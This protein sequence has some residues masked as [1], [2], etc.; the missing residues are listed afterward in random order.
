MIT[1]LIADDEPLTCNYLAS[2]FQSQNW[3][4][5][6]HTAYSGTE[7]LDAMAKTAFHLMLLDI[8]MPGA[9][10]LEIA[11]EASRLYP[12]TRILFL[13]AYDN[14][15]Y[16]YSAVSMN[17]R[18]YLLKI[19]P[20][21]VILEQVRKVIDEILE[22]QE[23]IIQIDEIRRKDLML[24]FLKQ[25]PIL[26][27]IC[28]SHDPEQIR[29]KLQSFPRDHVPQLS[30]PFYMMY[31]SHT[32]PADFLNGQPGMEEF[33]LENIQLM[34]SL[35]CGKLNCYILR[36][37]DSSFLYLFQ[38]MHPI[39]QSSDFVFL[40]RVA[41]E[42]ISTLSS[43]DSV[44]TTTLLY[45][46]PLSLSKISET[47]SA[48]KSCRD[49]VLPDSDSYAVFINKKE[50][51]QFSASSREK[52]ITKN[53]QILKLIQSY[54]DKNYV[55]KLT[56]SDIASLVHYNESYIS[57]L[58]KKETGQSVIEYITSVR[59]QKAKELLTTTSSSVQD[60][61]FAVGFD[62]PQY[63]SSTFRRQEGV[64]PT[65]YRIFRS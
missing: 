43:S 34:T 5:D 6:I 31:M 15:D 62:T 56:L 46:E 58:F 65:E 40:K 20:E 49:A 22:E 53:E 52:K 30:F 9:T 27:I 1:M 61:A 48:L 47:V 35:L 59:L 17:C 50:L 36:C 11:G 54:V 39:S 64:S 26:N 33:L 4:L 24:T 8:D 42:F 44:Q 37:N 13:T 7:V 45:M 55:S 19:E 60:I 38:P 41:D 3:D 28:S 14:F 29:K 23:N 10:G 32:F 16:I 63:F 21:H 25:Q 57:R 2:L 18:G 51:E 12:R